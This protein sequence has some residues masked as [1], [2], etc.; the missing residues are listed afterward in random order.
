MYIYI[1]YYFKIAYPETDL[2]PHLK[3]SSQASLR[4]V[5]VSA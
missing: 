3:S 5:P 2:A 1:Y 4:V